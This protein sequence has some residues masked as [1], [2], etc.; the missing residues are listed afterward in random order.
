MKLQF[1][2]ALYN[3]LTKAAIIVLLGVLIIVFIKNISINHIQARLKEKR[4]KI[5]G[6]LSAPEIKD[7]L[8]Q[9]GNYTDYNLLKE[10][11]FTLSNISKIENSKVKF[12]TEERTIEGGQLTYEILLQDFK[13]NGQLYRLELG[14]A[15]TTVDLLEKTILKFTLLILAASAIIT[16]VTDLFFSK[17]LLSPFYKIVDEKINKVNDPIHFNYVPIKT[18]TT[19]FVLLDESISMLMNKFRTFILTEKEFI[20]NVS[21][22]LLTPISILM[23]R[24]ENLL[25][26]ENLSTDGENKVFANLKTLNRL[27]SIINSL[28]MISKIEHQQYSRADE[29][30][31][32][33]VIADVVNELDHRLLMKNLSIEINLSKDFVFTGNAS[34]INILITNLVSNAIKYNVQNGEIRITANTNAQHFDLQI[35]DTGIGIAEAQLK[36]IFNRFEQLNHGEEDGHGLGLSIVKHIADFHGI[37]IAVNSVVGAGTTVF[38]KFLK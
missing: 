5:I 9:Q 23:V 8:A 20:A 18:T 25:N 24:M 27:K 7:F 38:L 33:E 32:K 17:Y 31:I 2:L 21:H 6:H 30:S 29:I 4:T 36:Q 16:L 22:E 37:Q 35:S 19:D 11:Y 15:L 12:T 34:L 28:L 10:E 26:E 3:T 13:H 1:K 14:E